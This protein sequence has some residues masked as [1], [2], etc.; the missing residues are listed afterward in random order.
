MNCLEDFAEDVYEISSNLTNLFKDFHR[1]LEDRGNVD[2]IVI[3]SSDE[4]YL[5]DES[6]EVYIKSRDKD[7]SLFTLLQFTI[8]DMLDNCAIKVIHDVTIIC[9][10]DFF[11]EVIKK[12]SDLLM[13]YRRCSSVMLTASEDES[14]WYDYIEP[15]AEK[16]G[17]NHSLIST[18]PSRD[19]SNTIK[20]LLLKKTI[21]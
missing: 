6:I 16:H 10:Q 7:G 3:Y 14:S 9:E 1:Y 2:S 21:K 5:I 8:S 18:F 4:P 13:N 17:N 19:P 11:V 20:M 12:M 15:L